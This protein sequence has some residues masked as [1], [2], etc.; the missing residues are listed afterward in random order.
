[1]S[2]KSEIQTDQVV[3]NNALPIIRK[4]A[5]SDLDSVFSALDTNAGSPLRL[6]ASNPSDSKLNI[7]AQEIQK[8]DGTGLSVPPLSSTIASIV[9]TTI[10]FQSLSTTGATVTI[11]WP[12]VVSGQYYRVGFTLIAGGTIQALFSAGAV[13]LGAVAN[14][15]TLFVNGGIPIGWVDLQATS[16]TQF[17][18]A[19]SSTSII[20]NSVSGTS[21]IHTF[22]SG[23]S[24]GS[25]SGSGIGDDLDVMTFRASFNDN[26]TEGTTSSACG[27]NGSAGFTNATYS[28]ANLLWALLYDASKTIAAGSTTTNILMS[29]APSFTVAVGDVVVIGGV[30]K[31]ITTVTSQ[32]N[33]TTEAFSSA[34]SLGTQVTVSQAVHTVDIYNYTGTGASLASAFSAISPNTFQEIMVDYKDNATL[35]SSLWT[36]NVAPFV[37]FSASTDNSNWSSQQVRATNETDTAGST[38]CPTAGTSLYI[39]FYSAAISGSGTVNILNYRALMQ[40]AAYPASSLVGNQA[41]GLTNVVGL[42]NN[43]TFSLVGGKTVATFPWSYPVGVN[44]GSAQGALD[45][46]MNGQRFPRSPVTGATLSSGYYTE[47]SANAIMFDTN[48]SG[49]AIEMQVFQPVVFVD[50]NTVNTTGIANLQEIQSQGFQSFVNTQSALLAPTTTTGTPVSGTFYSSITNRASLT[51]LSQDLRPR[52]GVERIITQEVY[53]IQNEFGSGGG[54]VYGVVNDT[55]GRIRC[56]GGW[57]SIDQAAGGQFI[58]ETGVFPNGYMEITFYGTGLNLLTF[59][60]GSTRNITASVDGGAFGANLLSSN[61]SNV[62]AAKQWTQNGVIHVV[63]GLTQGIHTVTL[64]NGNGTA[65][66]MII[67]G[68]EILNESSNVY[69]QPGVSYNAGKKVVTSA[70]VSF[71]YGAPASG[72]NGGRVLIYQNSDGSIGEA[73]QAVGSTLTFGSVNHSAEEVARVYHWRE[74]GAGR[75]DDFSSLGAGSAS[76]GFTLDDGTTT[77]V[78]LNA[79]VDPNVGSNTL[80]VTSGTT[81]YMEIAFV[82]TGLDIEFQIAAATNTRSVNFQVDNGATFGSIS[83]ANTSVLAPTIYQIVSGLPYGTHKVRIWNTQSAANSIGINRFIVYQPKKPSLPTGAIELGDYNVLANYVANATAGNQTIASGVVR[84]YAMRDVIYRGTTGW[85]INQNLSE[86]TPY[87]LVANASSSNAFDY[88]FFGTGTEI[89]FSGNG[90]AVT[91]QGT[92]TDSANPGGTSNFLAAGATTSFYGAN[93]A[94][95]TNTTATLVLNTTSTANCGLV[96]SGLALGWHTISFRF[97]SGSGGLNINAFDTITPIHSYKSN[98]YADIQN[99]LTVGSNSLSDNRKITPIAGLPSAKGWAQTTGISSGPTTTSTV[100]VPCPDMSCTVKTSGGPLYIS[101]AI[102]FQNNTS[103]GLTDFA[104]YVDGVSIG[105]SKNVQAYTGGAT[106]SVADQ[107]IVPVSAGSH[108]VDV[109]WLVGSGTATAISLNRNLTVREL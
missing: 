87:Q 71:A 70:Q 109:Y 17:K 33:Y 37:A 11:S 15:G 32:A 83:I 102:T 96:I 104:I 84:K 31:K 92:L 81:N 22:G 14:P 18:T 47:Y 6:F 50:T 67:S 48:Y 57:V 77:L 10:D 19:G 103:G 58:D 5:A 59:Y 43:V 88:T 28:P 20:E 36:P 90:V 78:A 52:M 64:K 44:S 76:K 85:T 101:Y 91:W 56:V 69:V 2:G 82:G 68:I 16:T 100:F 3:T 97:I 42:Q 55:F 38:V 107:A 30:V 46:T 75:S 66:D 65:P 62:M 35:N 41:F 9:A 106:M 89:R 51:D 12:T 4:A 79:I 34:P 94:S 98:S 108:K 27:V 61:A 93:V 105:T 1:M 21:T 23:G 73:F 63:G 7:A 74:F 25:G 49:V 26:F 8:A 60:D 72:S 40:K 86:T 29:S 80:A 99:T 24:G 45:V 53:L 54:N 13:S 95:F 39:R